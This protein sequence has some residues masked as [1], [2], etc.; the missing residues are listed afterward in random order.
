[1]VDSRSTPDEA[2]FTLTEMLVALGIL[3]FGLTALAGSMFQGAGERRGSEMRFRAVHMVDRVFY[4]IR[5]EVLPAIPLD[6]PLPAE[7]PVVEDLPGYPGLKYRVKFFTDE[8]DPQVVLVRVWITWK[9][10][11]ELVADYFDRA[12]VR[13]VPF[14]RRISQLKMGQSR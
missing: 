9:E 4:E 13:E 11:G 3:M 2:G 10:K 8:L 14:S 5:E 7:L 1:M 12:M 6:E